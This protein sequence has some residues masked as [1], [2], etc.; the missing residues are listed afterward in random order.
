MRICFLAP[1]NSAHIKKWSKYFVS[2]G[3]EVHIVSF[4]NGEIP[5]TTVHFI[6]AGV[7]TDSDD[8]KKLRYLLMA[9]RV[10]K[11]VSQ[12]GPDVINVHYATS[13]G[14]VAALAGLKDYIVSVWGSDI[15]D[16]PKKSLLHKELLKF[17]LR[18]APNLFS[19]SKAMAD[20]A[21][22]YTTKHFEITPFGVETD[23]FSPDKR[24]RND[25]YFVIGT[26]KA[27]SYKYGIDFLLEAA[28]IVRN[29]HPE[30]PLKVR[31]AGK[32][33]DETTFKQLSD[34]LKI[35]DIVVWLGFISQE[36]AS[37]EWANMD[38]AVVYSTL[39]SESFGVSAVEAQACACPVI[40]SDVPGL[41]EATKPGVT[42]LV[43]PRKDARA[44][45]EAIACLYYDKKKRSELGT[46]GRNFVI[47]N[48]EYKM[49]FERIEALYGTLQRKKRGSALE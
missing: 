38:L 44:L 10:R 11:I 2:K 32:G 17:S 6:D 45:A 18:K 33:P 14:T 1:A 37:I 46:N 24:N 40:I 35:A 48:F 19:T 13:Y 26:V 36:Q 21:A 7:D 3:Y 34:D 42:S 25:S 41:M 4:T 8:G 5:G 15:Y 43:V 23:L 29:E 39:E 49:C 9:G 30:I 22:K 31:I 47:D 12:I 27:M 28:A 20:E 16:F